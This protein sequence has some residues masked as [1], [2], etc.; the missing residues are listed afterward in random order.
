MGRKFAIPKIKFFENISGMFITIVRVSCFTGVSVE[1]LELRTKGDSGKCFDR[2][3]D[4][5]VRGIKLDLIIAVRIAGRTTDKECIFSYES[6]AA[7]Y[8]VVD[9]TMLV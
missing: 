3:L 1:R 5:A 9:D 7:L 2:R 6:C 4:F 8:K